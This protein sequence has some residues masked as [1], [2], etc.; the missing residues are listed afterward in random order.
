[1]TDPAGR[2]LLTGLYAGQGWAADAE[3]G[4]QSKQSRDRM[5]SDL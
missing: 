1:M 2:R 3:E 4:P 5:F